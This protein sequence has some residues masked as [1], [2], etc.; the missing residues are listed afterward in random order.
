M[1]RCAT[2]ADGMRQAGA[3]VGVAIGFA[4][5][6]SLAAG[7]EQVLDIQDVPT[8]LTAPGRDGGR[9]GAGGS[10]AT[11]GPADS[12]AG[13][14]EAPSDSGSSQLDGSLPALSCFVTDA[15]YMLDPSA[16]LTPS[17]LACATD[18]S[19]CAG[20]LSACT[21]S[22]VCPCLFLCI[23]ECSA[24]AGGD[25]ASSGCLSGCTAQ[26][27]PDQ[28]SASTYQCLTQTCGAACSPL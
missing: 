2:F 7:C 21:E 15:P 1:A 24:D 14:D 16:V 3:V 11:S 5:S 26:L 20:A 13:D 22:Q 25:G 4:A 23:V 10:D 17:C 9:D 19:G 12:G 8:P 27:T 18:A 6:L 28:I